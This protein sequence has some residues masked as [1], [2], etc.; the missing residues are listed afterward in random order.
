MKF[1]R[2]IS[3]PG[4]HGLYF[5]RMNNSLVFY[6]DLYGEGSYPILTVITED[7]SK[8]KHELI[9]KYPNGWGYILVPQRDMFIGEFDLSHLL[10][11]NTG[12]KSYLPELLEL[13]KLYKTKHD[14]P[15]FNL[16]ER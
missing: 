15:P 1:T 4:C 13:E 8:Y 16:K 11:Y 10:A 14:L 12:D 7:I 2:Y 5:L 9:D 6:A 3:F